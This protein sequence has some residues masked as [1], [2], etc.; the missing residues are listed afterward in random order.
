MSLCTQVG[1]PT[2]LQLQ[3]VTADGMSVVGPPRLLIR[4]NQTW[5][6]PVIE[7]PYLV[8]REVSKLSTPSM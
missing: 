7:A 2:W 8:L 1:L 3:Q 4:N 5:E 6:G